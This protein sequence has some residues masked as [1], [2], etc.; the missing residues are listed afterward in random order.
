VSETKKQLGQHWLNDPG[1]LG[2][3]ADAADLQSGEVV[4]EIGPGLGSLTD[5]LSDRGAKVT[6]LEFDQDLI[7]GLRIKYNTSQVK[8]VQG[9]IR[10]FNFSELP[11]KYKIVANI[12]YYLTSHLIRSISETANPPS[13]AVLLIQKE[14]AERLCAKPGQMSI[15]AVTAQYYFNCNLDIE[16]PARY[17]TPPPK[18][19]SQV[20]VLRRRTEKMFDVDEQEFFRIVK[21]GFSEKRKTL[22]NSLSGGLQMTKEEAVR[23]LGKADLLPTRRAQELSMYD[24]YDLYQAYNN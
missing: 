5:V 20:V 15:L 22:R 9:D 21:A 1:V 13:I 8:I 19:D 17:F 16:V 18:V 3:I 6:A 7:K 23:L 14:V 12:P 2:S 11:E 10:T 4:L 24:W